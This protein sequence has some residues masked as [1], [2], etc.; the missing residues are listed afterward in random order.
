LGRLRFWKPPGIIAMAVM[1]SFRQSTMG[2]GSILMPLTV[3]R[4]LAVVAAVLIYEGRATGGSVH[5]Q[6]LT[7]SRT[8]PA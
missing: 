1:G 8:V 5:S 4:A 2:V 6:P 3:V 7:V